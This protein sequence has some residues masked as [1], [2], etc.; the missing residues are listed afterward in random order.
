[1]KTITQFLLVL[2]TGFIVCTVSCNQDDKNDDPEPT[3]TIV[4]K[5]ATNVTENSFTANWT[6]NRTGITITIIEV[7]VQSDFSSIMKTITVNPP[8]TTSQIIDGLNGATTYYFRVNITLDDGTSGIS[9]SRDQLTYYHTED[10]DVTTSDGL[11]IGGKICYLESISVK[12][13]GVLLLGVMELSNLW[14]NEETF[15]KLVA[16]GYVCY[17]FDWRGHGQSDAFPLPQP[18]EDDIVYYIDNYYKLDLTA[19]YNYL[20]NH[21]QVDSTKLALAGGSLGANMSLVGNSWN[22][23]K[24]SVALSASQAGLNL[25][26]PLQNVLYIVC[27]N[28]C[29]SIFNFCFVDHATQLYE[30]N[31][32]DPKKLVILPGDHHGLDV[33]GLP[34]VS[35]EIVDWINA[36][37]EE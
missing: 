24:A 28:D 20:K 25:A 31:T 13:P 11:N 23:I 12:K 3:L 21:P 26:Q 17:I 4:L 33:M 9:N 16:A 14:K 30:N 35:T 15:N 8:S 5:D 34:G 10:V 7:S 22:N 2:V 19:C 32:I 18:T 29:S 37:M 27:E 36:R 6:V 1:M